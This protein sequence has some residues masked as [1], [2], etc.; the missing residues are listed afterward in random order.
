WVF[1][2][3]AFKGTPPVGF[4]GKALPLF[5]GVANLLSGLAR[6]RAPTTDGRLSARDAHLFGRLQCGATVQG[7]SP[8]SCSSRPELSSRATIPRRERSRERPSFRT[9][10]RSNR[11]AD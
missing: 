1:Y 10:S 4:L 9:P 11:A 5:P 3:P 2:D 7:S 8:F 6:F